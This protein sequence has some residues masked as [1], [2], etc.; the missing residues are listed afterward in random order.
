MEKT[1]ANCKY[2]HRFNSDAPCNSCS[3]R[4]IP[5]NESRGIADCWILH[6][7]LSA[8]EETAST[9]HPD[10]YL[11]NG[12]KCFQA[13][14]AATDNLI[15]ADAFDTGNAIKYLWRWKDKNGVEDLKKAITYIQ[16]IIGREEP[17][18]N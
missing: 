11:K 3:R 15:G 13:I 8:S 18:A 14:D 10:Y 16:R 5:H 1:C 12:V 6:P 2:S 7:G 4:F 9:S 17:H